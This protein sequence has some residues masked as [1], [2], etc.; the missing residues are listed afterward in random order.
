MKQPKK[1][2][3]NRNISTVDKDISK[4]E[5]KENQEK[6]TIE[7][8]SEEKGE[9]KLEALSPQEVKMFC[10]WEHTFKDHLFQAWTNYNKYFRG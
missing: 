1:I 9:A 6:T 7:S 5:G 2:V 8:S 10:S 3:L 4:T